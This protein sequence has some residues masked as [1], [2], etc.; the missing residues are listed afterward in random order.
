MIVA[1]LLNYISFFTPTAYAQAAD[2]TIEE[3]INIID[4]VV[5]ESDPISAWKLDETSGSTATDVV[6][7]NNGTLINM[8]AGD[9][10]AGEVANGLI[11]D[12]SNETV[13]AG[14]PTNL[15]LERTSPM[16]FEAWI[17]TSTD[18][19]MTIFSKQESSAPFRGYNFQTGSGGFSFSSS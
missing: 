15:Q 2:P 6:D 12:G 10:V 8:E 19:G 11:F 7:S 14:N 16:T 1:L 5:T 17:K 13:D 3:Q 4:Q 9:W 18:G